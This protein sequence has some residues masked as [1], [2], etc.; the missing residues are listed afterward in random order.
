MDTAGGFNIWHDLSYVQGRAIGIA[1]LLDCESYKTSSK[2]VVSS[3][4]TYEII[5][6]DINV[7]NWSLQLYAS[8]ISV[9]LG[10]IEVKPYRCD[11]AVDCMRLIPSD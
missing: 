6:L 11:L 5:S 2:C 1:A 7:I 8:E 4:V 3:S 9:A 10:T